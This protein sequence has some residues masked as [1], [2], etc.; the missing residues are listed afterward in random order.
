MTGTRIRCVRFGHDE[1]RCASA[2][3]NEER[4]HVYP[5]GIVPVFPRSKWSWLTMKEV[6]LLQGSQNSSPFGVAKNSSSTL[7]KRA[8]LQSRHTQVEAHG[9]KARTSV[10]EPTTIISRNN[11]VYVL[12]T[13]TKDRQLALDNSSHVQMS[14]ACLEEDRDCLPGAV[15]N[16]LTLNCNRVQ[17]KS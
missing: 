14:P 11:R 9:V 15:P 12:D 13:M 10:E 5:D 2:H 17:R 7:L 6:M 3:A 4:K 8:Q 16:M 1:G